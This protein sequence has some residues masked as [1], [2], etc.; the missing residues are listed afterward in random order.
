M[1]SKNKKYNIWYVKNMEYLPV[2]FGY[3]TFI[4]DEID[5]LRVVKF[6]ESNFHNSNMFAIYHN[7][8]VISK[9]VDRN[10]EE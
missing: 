6:S 3:P 8:T 5:M 4:E 2:F 1:T 10:E 7:D 9:T